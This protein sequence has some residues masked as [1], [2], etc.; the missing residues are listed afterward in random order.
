MD[1]HEL[2]ELAR[3]LEGYADDLKT[4]HIGYSMSIRQCADK[5]RRYL[6]AEEEME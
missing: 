5:L 3:K 2:L 1:N 4:V 6:E